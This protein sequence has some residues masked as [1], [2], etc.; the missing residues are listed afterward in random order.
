MN[1]ALS[2]M[3]RD[4][5]R[6]LSKSLGLKGYSKLNRD[7]L[8]GFIRATYMEARRFKAQAPMTTDARLNAYQRS[9]GDRPLTARQQRQVDRM[10]RR[11]ERSKGVR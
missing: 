11:M 1:K 5:L 7:E 4:E 9:N 3:T 8:E 6:S 2:A 10:A